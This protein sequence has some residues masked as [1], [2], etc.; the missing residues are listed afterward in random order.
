MLVTSLMFKVKS[1]FDMRTT[2][3]QVLDRYLNLLFTQILFTYFPSA[4]IKSIY[5]RSI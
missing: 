2:R 3:L 4:V 5:L 1:K